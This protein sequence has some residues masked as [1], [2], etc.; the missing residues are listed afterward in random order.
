MHA[1]RLPPV[2]PTSRPWWARS[3]DFLAELVAGARH[4]AVAPRRSAVSLP[5]A[6]APQ[7][8]R[9]LAGLSAQMQADIGLPDA[10]RAYGQA[11]QERDALRIRW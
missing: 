8:M 1:S 2:L 5:A 7:A 9:P 11:L 10:L 3:M 4:I 6:Q